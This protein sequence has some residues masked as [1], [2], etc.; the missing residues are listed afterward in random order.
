MKWLIPAISV[1]CGFKLAIAL[2][3]FIRFLE[4]K[5]KVIFW[6]SIGWMFFGLHSIIEL[7]LLLTGIEWLWFPRHIA[8]AFTAVA[9]L[10]SV[11]HMQM[12]TPRKWHIVSI[13]IGLTAVLSS[14]TAQE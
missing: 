3:L 6:W 14:Y 8:Y 11:G 5:D 12:P 4:T 9:F 10:E 13:I 1:D 7:T 2:T